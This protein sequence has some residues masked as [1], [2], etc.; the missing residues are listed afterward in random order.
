LNK[1]NGNGSLTALPIIETQMG[2]VAGYIPTNVISITDGQIF[3]ETDLFN[4]G[5]RPAVSVGL[6]VSRVG[7]AAQIKAYK[8]VA[9]K[10]KLELAQFRELA[11]FSQFESDLDATT[12][13]RLDRGARIVEMFK[14][15]A[16]SPVP[17]EIQTAVMWAMQNDFF[18]TIPVPQIA[19]AV[20]SLKE[21]LATQGTE[22]CSEIYNSGKLEEDTEQK[23]K[24]AVEDWKRTFA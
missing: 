7:S 16:Y 20:D 19:E 8:K 4:K 17:V 15:G 1:D 23:L 3:L 9:G 12:K 24:R 5:I 11:A 2:D 18:D 21:Y 22:P 10:V 14:Q 13:A 6:S